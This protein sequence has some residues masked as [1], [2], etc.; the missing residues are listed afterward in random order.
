M[1]AILEWFTEWFW[2]QYWLSRRWTSLWKGLPAMICMGIAVAGL[3]AVCRQGG[4]VLAARYDDAATRVRDG[5]NPVVEDL[6]LRRLLVLQPANRRTRYQYAAALARQNENGG[7]TQI[8]SSLAPLD[9]SGYAPAHYWLAQQSM[10]TKTELSAAKVKLLEQRL[11]LSLVGEDAQPAARL[12]LVAIA[13]RSKRWEVA[14]QHL[15]ELVP[16]RPDLQL[17]LASVYRQQGNEIRATATSGRASA[18][19]ARLVHQAPHDDA[20]RLHWAEA[21]VFQRNLREALKV[22]QAA[23]A[24]ET[25]PRY[26][27]AIA[28]VFLMRMA[29]ARTTS[30]PSELSTSADAMT[31]A[32]RPVST[33]EL[34]SQIELLERAI[35]YAPNHPVVLNAIAQL[36]TQETPEGDQARSW[37]KDALARGDS[38]ATVHLILGTAAATKGDMKDAIFHLEQAVKRDPKLAM[39][40]NNLAY[41]LADSDP[42]QPERALRLVDAA[43]Q[44][45]PQH[46]EIRETRGQ[47]LLLLGRHQEAILDLEYVLKKLPSR[48]RVHAGLAA[49]YRALG[50]PDLAERHKR[51]AEEQENQPVLTQPQH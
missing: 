1:M 18:Y 20:S 3:A 44:V 36:S 15:E 29:G 47:I 22:L 26:G 25:D 2:P 38:P 21:L 17:A 31:P 39:A 8:M 19:Y 30:A 7:G 24:A 9:R 13:L 23:D 33:L 35:H 10:N 40:A 34:A 42:S 43:L 49:A 14:A 48:R 27:A 4:S 12:Q 28:Q 41:V 45:M 11:E 37:L 51:M 5:S 46:P 16:R 6:C 32:N 50:N